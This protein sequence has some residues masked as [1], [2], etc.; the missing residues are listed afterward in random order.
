MEY[1]GVQIEVGKRYKS[2]KTLRTDSL[3]SDYI[4]RKGKYVTV[5]EIGG[6]C[7]YLGDLVFI[8]DM[9][10]DREHHHTAKATVK[11][12]KMSLAEFV[13]TFEPVEENFHK[14]PQV[15]KLYLIKIHEKYTHDRSA[16]S[17]NNYW[18]DPQACCYETELTYLV[19]T[20]R[21]SRAEDKAYTLLKELREAARKDDW[22]THREYHISI[23]QEVGIEDLD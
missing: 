21:R 17:H 23:V 2:N 7:V 15:P 4:F 9:Y 14:P 12:F 3:S 13:R 19:R 10:S 8:A 6:A 20:V 5:K 22:Y 1:C 11:D 16:G 18:R